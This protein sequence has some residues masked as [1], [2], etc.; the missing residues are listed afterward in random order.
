MRKVVNFISR[1]CDCAIEFSRFLK[2]NFDAI[3][4]LNNR[5]RWWSQLFHIYSWDEE[6]KHKKLILNFSRLTGFGGVQ[7]R[8]ETRTDHL[9]VLGRFQPIEAQ[10]NRKMYFD[11]GGRDFGAVEGVGLLNKFK[12]QRFLFFLKMFFKGEQG[13]KHMLYSKNY[14][15]YFSTLNSPVYGFIYITYA[16]EWPFWRPFSFNLPY[17]ELFSEVLTLNRLSRTT[18][19]KNFDFD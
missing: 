4:M 19:L 10:K 9:R 14:L 15:K 12:I 17:S 7:S 11:V 3:F 8:R 2:T 16:D 6:V 13:L 1:F 5:I 18:F